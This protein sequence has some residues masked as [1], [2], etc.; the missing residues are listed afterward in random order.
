[1]GRAGSRFRGP[2][3]KKAPRRDDGPALAAFRRVKGL[4]AELAA[5][6]DAE[7][8]HRLHCLLVADVVTRAA[9]DTAGLALSP[10]QEE[11]AARFLSTGRP[12]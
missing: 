12:P 6:L 1:M 9:F 7:D 5:E 3:A 10:A 2:S 4:L 8:E 11:A